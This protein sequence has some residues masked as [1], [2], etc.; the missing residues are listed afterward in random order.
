MRSDST[1]RSPTVIYEY[2]KPKTGTWY[3]SIGLRDG[4]AVRDFGPAS[5]IAGS[6]K[7]N[8]S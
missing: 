4:T 5:A 7:F 2:L 3:P 6:L 8:T 1:P